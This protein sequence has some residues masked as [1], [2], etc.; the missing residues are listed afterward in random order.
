MVSAKLNVNKKKK[1]CKYY[2]KYVSD[3]LSSSIEGLIAI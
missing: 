2:R 3:K 1:N